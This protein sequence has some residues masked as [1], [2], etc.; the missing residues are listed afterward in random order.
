MAR[1]CA[2]EAAR[3]VSNDP[4]ERSCLGAALTDAEITI[5]LLAVANDGW[6]CL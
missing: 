4:A 2:T 5:E 3:N 1:S 6:L